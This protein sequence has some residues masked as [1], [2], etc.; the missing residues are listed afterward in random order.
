[1]VFDNRG[2]YPRFSARSFL[3]RPR[4][5]ETSDVIEVD[6]NTLS[7]AAW[8]IVHS[9]VLEGGLIAAAVEVEIRRDDEFIV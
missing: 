9:F 2:Y 4:R 1:M 5:L 7:A 8:G 3:Q 6:A